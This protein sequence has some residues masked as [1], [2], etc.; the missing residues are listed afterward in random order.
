M[1]DHRLDHPNVKPGVTVLIDG[2]GCAS[3]GFNEEGAALYDYNALLEHFH[4]CEGMGDSESEDES[5]TAAADWVSY[6]VVRALAYI[7]EGVR[8]ILVDEYLCPIDEEDC[9]E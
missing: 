2:A 5:G 8:P 1:C 6:N 9:R 7:T 4:T 3:V